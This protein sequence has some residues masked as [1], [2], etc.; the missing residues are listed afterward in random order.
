MSTLRITGTVS[1]QAQPATGTDG[2][3]W[4]SV[5]LAQQDPHAAPCRA[6]QCFG[7]GHAAQ[8]AATNAARRLRK[9]ATI[10]V[11]AATFDLRFSP[12]PHLVLWGVDLIEQLALPA[13]PATADQ[14]EREAA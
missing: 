3:A 1:A 9:G 12:K 10:T 2:S 5:E 14:P 8:F 4:L 7:T 11:H 13:H 6:Q